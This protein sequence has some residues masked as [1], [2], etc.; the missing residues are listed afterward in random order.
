MAHSYYRLLRPLGNRGLSG[1]LVRAFRKP[2]AI[3]APEPPHPFDLRHGTDT[4]S[5]VSSADLRR[6]SR[7][8]LSAG[9]AALGVAP[10]ALTQAISNL[11]LY[12]EN[13]SFVDLGCGKGRALLVAA[14]FPFRN[15]LGVETASDLCTAARANIASNPSW[16]ARA[17]ILKQAAATVTYPDSPLVI[18]L[19]DSVLAP[20]LRHVL[21]NL[22]RQFNRLPRE[23]YLV[24]ANNPRFTKAID[25][26]PFLREISNTPHALSPE[27]AA[28]ARFQLTHERFRVFTATLTR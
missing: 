17:T 27:D 7:C 24:C 15:L 25:R 13:F 21:A 11:P 19:F 23:T 18:F 9:A 16:A 26:F 28:V 1:N 8:S 12:P 5:F 22:E 20:G 14:E 4:G 10:S 3:P 6:N 2:P